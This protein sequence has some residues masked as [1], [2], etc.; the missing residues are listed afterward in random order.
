MVRQK[1]VTEAAVWKRL[2]ELQALV[3]MD[4]RATVVRWHRM[5]ELR[6]I[7]GQPREPYPDAG[8]TSTNLFGDPAPERERF[9]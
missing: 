4:K 1:S 3:P 6:R 9:Q 5:D 2:R 7:L 8:D